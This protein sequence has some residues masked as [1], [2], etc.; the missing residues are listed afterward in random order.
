MNAIKTKDEINIDRNSLMNKIY[1]GKFTPTKMF[2]N[3]HSDHF[4]KEH[5]PDRAELEHAPYRN[6]AW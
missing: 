6:I 2:I 3:E 4:E 5:V 1:I